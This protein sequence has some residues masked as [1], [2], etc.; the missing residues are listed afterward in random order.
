MVVAAAAF[1]A[2]RRSHPP[3]KP[4]TASANAPNKTKDERMQG[5]LLYRNINIKVRFCTSLHLRCNILIQNSRRSQWCVCCGS[6]QAEL[7][8]SRRQRASAAC[9]PLMSMRPSLLGMAGF[10][11]LLT[12][13]VW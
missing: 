5:I 6:L 4:P 13:G 3:R 11:T 8:C 7:R 10:C 9:R 12:A 1:A 2:R